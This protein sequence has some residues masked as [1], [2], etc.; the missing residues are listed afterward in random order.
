[1]LSN[2][3]YNKL[4]FFYTFLFLHSLLHSQII[5]GHITDP[6][7]GKGISNVSFTIADT[8]VH[9]DS[10]GYYI[11][12]I[13]SSTG[14]KNKFDTNISPTKYSLLQNYPNPFN[15]VTIIE[16][17]LP[18]KSN[19]KIIIYNIHGQIVKIL[20]NCEKA[21]GKHFVLWNGK[22]SDNATV[23]SGIYFLNMIADSYNKS[24]KLILIE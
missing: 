5:Q 9:T 23:N 24:I 12:D 14:L 1:M 17:Q 8:T 13:S 6:L 3:K 19:I 7:T 22:D 21:S 15:S 11:I 18:K 2:I 4:I 20:E 16:Y 10:T